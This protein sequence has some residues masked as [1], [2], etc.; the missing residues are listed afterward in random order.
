MDLGQPDASGDRTIH[1][2]ISKDQ[3]YQ[4]QIGGQPIPDEKNVL[5]TK[6]HQPLPMDLAE[7]IKGMYRLLD[8]ISESGSNGCG[9]DNT[10]VMRYTRTDLLLS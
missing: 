2:P 10:F 3:S 7:E 9:N 5:K 6:A 8:L 1:P 4:Q